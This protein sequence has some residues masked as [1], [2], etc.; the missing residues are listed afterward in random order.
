[1][2][3]SLRQFRTFRE[4]AE[5]GTVTAAAESL[6]YTPSAVSQQLATFERSVGVALTERSGRKLQLTD[7][8]REMLRHCIELLQRAEL[9]QV[10]VERSQ[11]EPR[12]RV[13]VGV[14][15]SIISGLLVPSL[16]KVAVTAPEVE[17]H[18]RQIIDPDV[19]FD[20]VLRGSVDAAFAI[21]YPHAP[22]ALPPDVERR[23]VSTDKY[24]VVVPENDEIG[25]APVSLM[26]LK[27][28]PWIGSPSDTNCGR[29]VFTAA[30]SAGFEPDLRHCIDDFPAAMRLIAGGAGVALI[31]AMALR[32][33]PRGL[34]L[35]E[36]AEPIERTI[37]LVHRRS[38]AGRP[39]LEVFVSAVMEAA[40]ELDVR[41]L[42]DA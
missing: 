22:S 2:D 11:Q 5:L 8:G 3:V 12:G 27:D 19:A 38:S 17:I 15:E 20:E 6:G 35:I 34:R 16:V 10:A 33:R 14:F 18:S 21:D 32:H 39:A 41:N 37:D 28:R 36:P 23:R 30:R 13:D 42:V 9:A 25:D 26:D 31:P 24:M 29:S 7:A 1:M 40:L 4:V